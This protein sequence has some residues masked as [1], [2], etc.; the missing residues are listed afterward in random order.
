MS[1][2]PLG[3]PHEA[4]ASVSTDLVGESFVRN[5]VPVI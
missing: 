5:P 2:V 4:A 3:N 1:A